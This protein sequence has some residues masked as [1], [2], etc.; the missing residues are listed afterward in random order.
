M[1]LLIN[2]SRPGSA[3][4][5]AKTPKLMRMSKPINQ[6]VTGQNE[7]ALGRAKSSRRCDDLRASAPRIRRTTVFMAPNGTPFWRSCQKV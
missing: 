5:A 6:S 1:Q 2:P 3:S 7:S 4:S